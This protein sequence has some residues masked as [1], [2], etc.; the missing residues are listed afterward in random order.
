MRN[1]FVPSVV[2][3][4]PAASCLVPFSPHISYKSRYRRSAIHIKQGSCIMGASLAADFMLLMAAA[5]ILAGAASG[6]WA[7]SEAYIDPPTTDHE[8]PTLF[9]VTMVYRNGT[10]AGQQGAG[11]QT[12]DQTGNITVNI[13]SVQL[14]L[15]G[16]RTDSR[17]GESRFMLTRANGTDRFSIRLGPWSPGEEFPYHFETNLSNGSML[18]TNESWLRTPDVI[19]FR[20]HDS[21]SEASGLASSLARPLLVF[22]YSARDHSSDYMFSG[23]FSEAASVALSADFVCLRV[24]A[25]TDPALAGQLN[26]SSTPG[27]VFLNASTGRTL[28]KLSG[29]FD[30]G[31]LVKQMRYILQKGSRP[32]KPAPFVTDIV[33]ETTALGIVLVAGSALMFNY[34]FRKQRMER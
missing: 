11:N 20:W 2:T 30:T 6:E 28:D 22:V 15:G 5:T 32:A 25:D 1:I 24:D 34:Y 18:R 14:V 31:T 26:M 12:G 21:Y 19:G 13:T 17:S 29:P 7:F 8:R 9:Y 33:I 27:L 10:V 3:L 16:N 4:L 23:P